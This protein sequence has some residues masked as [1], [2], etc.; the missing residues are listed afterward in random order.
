MPTL[1]D[2]LAEELSRRLTATD[3]PSKGTPAID[4]TGL[5]V[6]LPGPQT[7]AYHSEADELFYGGGG[8]GGKTD[9]LLGVAITK[10]RSAV[11]F[12]R[13]A[14]QL[15]GPEGI[16]ERSRQ[17]IGIH[18]R[19]N[20]NLKIWRG[21]PGDRSLEFGGVKDEAS[22]NKWKG[23]AH[24]LKAFDEL[25]EFTESQYRFLITW[26]RSTFPGQRTRVIGTGNP[27]TSAAGEWILRYWAPW[28]D[29]RH[30]NPAKAGELRWFVH[31][32]GADQEVPTGDPVEVEG[33]MVRPRSRTFIPAAV[34]DNPH[35]FN[36]G[37][38]DVLDS[39]PEPLRSQMRHGD[40]AATQGDNPWQVIP[41]AW[42][43]AAQDRWRNRPS[44]IGTI[45][46][47]AI[48]VDPAR[49]GPDK[50]GIAKRYDNWVA[51]II[52]H[53]G[54]AAPDGAAGA[55]L[56][57]EALGTEDAPAQI[58]VGG[59]A[60][61]STYDHY[62]VLKAGTIALNGSE[63]SKAR[64][65]SGKLGFYNKRAEWHW[66]LRE[67]LDPTSG[68][69]IAL[70]DDPELLADLVAPRWMLTPRGI[71]VEKKEEIKKRIGRSPDTGE[72][73][74]YTFAGGGDAFFEAIKRQHARMK[75]AQAKQGGSA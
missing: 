16:I 23:R 17:I 31:L 24:D 71:Q 68:Q 55:R 57:L 75:A 64:D 9:L 37:Y 29:P 72:A 69:E 15:Q 53:P 27:P 12:R 30:P 40:F 65:K 5:W 8:G 44:P 67:L 22:K 3:D 2:S 49:G 46:L 33:R 26:L 18:G 63:A 50:F 59:Q 19:L 52:K 43:K 34:E 62:K 38:A 6:P 32:D 39:L 48:G 28:L 60:G 25:P 14:A 74:I 66:H 11:I 20:E 54:A 51:P 10:H 47:S 42:V 13:E 73:C 61:S 41:T 35:L 70:P 58:D 21:L 7:M 1:Y 36:A 56:V 4:P 45:P